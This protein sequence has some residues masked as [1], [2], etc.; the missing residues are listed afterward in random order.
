MYL[1]EDWE[2]SDPAIKGYRAALTAV[3][4]LRGKKL[5]DCLC[6]R[7]L[8]YHF[9]QSSLPRECKPLAWDFMLVLHHLSGPPYEP[10]K[11]ASDKD[12]TLMS[13]FF[14]FFC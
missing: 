13:F 3:Q 8:F 10:L 6:I 2:L 12:L 14:F 9:E 1:K 5:S 7:L 11:L 4:V